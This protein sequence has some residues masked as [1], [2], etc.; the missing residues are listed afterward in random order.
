MG[1]KDYDKTLRRLTQIL[2]KL[3][4]NERLNTKEFAEEFNVSVRTIQ[5]DIKDNLCEFPII[6]DSNGK[7]MFQEGFSLNRTVLDNDEMMFLKIALSQFTD[8]KNIDLIKNRIFKKLSTKNFFNPYY[9]KQDDIEDIDID[10][11]FIERLEKYINNQEI[12][13][14]SLNSKIVE[15]EA[16]KIVNF[17][18]FWYFFA[19][20]LHDNKTKTFK[21]SEIKK[22]SSTQR[23]Y[24]TT[25]QEIEKI[26]DN[27]HSAFYSDGN[28][29]EVII[30]VYKEV[31]PYF[32]NKDFLES[33]NILEEYSDASLRVSFKI[34]HDEDIDNIIKAWLPHVEILEPLRFK[35]KLIN[36]LEDYLKKIKAK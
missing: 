3:S 9:V 1:K 20:D 31:A 5:K 29:F 18:G 8:V 30:K 35:E 34:S 23:Y 13:S 12:L 19:K 24:K 7:F 36:E 6:K 33:Q 22:I 32:K 28:S 26:L 16:Y 27:A 10:S 25:V 15:V 17:D 11:I 4:Y 21:L 14:L 2:S